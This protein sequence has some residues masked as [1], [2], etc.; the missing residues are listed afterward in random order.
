MSK[1]P[2]KAWSVMTSSAVGVDP[3]EAMRSLPKLGSVHH[4][5]TCMSHSAEM[6]PRGFFGWLFGRP[7]QW[8]VTTVY[9]PDVRLPAAKQPM[10]QPK[11][12]NIT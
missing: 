2:Y 4:G 8:M 11:T 5:L 6:I 3:Q 1:S 7:Q 12:E 10:P 9:E